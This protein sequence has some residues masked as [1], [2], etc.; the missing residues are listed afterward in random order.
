MTTTYELVVT[1]YQRAAHA[2]TPAMIFDCAQSATSQGSSFAGISIGTS[3][4]PAG[5]WEHVKTFDYAVDVDAKSIEATKIHILEDLMPGTKL[6]RHHQSRK[7][8]SRQFICRGRPRMRYGFIL[9]RSFISDRTFQNTNPESMY[10]FRE[11][12]V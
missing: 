1:S 8:C 10:V 9:L 6:F 7:G 5:D 2:C 4:I 3:R 12:G 11:G